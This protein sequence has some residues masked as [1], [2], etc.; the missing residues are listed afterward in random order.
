M[1]SWVSGLV[2]Y[3]NIDCVLVTLPLH[4]PSFFGLPSALVGFLPIS[5]Q[6]A[7]ASALKD[8]RG[9]EAREVN[10]FIHLCPFARP[11]FLQWLCSFATQYLS[12]S[13][14]ITIAL[15]ESNNAMPPCL[16]KACVW[17]WASPCLSP[18]FTILCWIF[19]S[20]FAPL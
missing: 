2:L 11:W 3:S 4:S 8:I 1:P 13:S 17:C 10:L 15:P 16:Y 5:F 18:V 14:S 7:L 6:L 9:Q 20:L 19:L 12:G